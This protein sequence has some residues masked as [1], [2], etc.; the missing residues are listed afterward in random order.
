MET[1]GWAEHG[2]VPVIRSFGVQ[3]LPEW[4]LGLPVRNCRGSADRTGATAYSAKRERERER[5]PAAGKL[6]PA[7]GRHNSAQ[8]RRCS[9][10]E[11]S[12]GGRGF[13]T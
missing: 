1:A 12:W 6:E 5:R 7:P 3:G 2:P 10:R 4:R 13:C 9:I 11:E 8:D